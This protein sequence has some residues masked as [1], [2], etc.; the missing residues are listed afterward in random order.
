V[1]SGQIERSYLAK[2]SDNGEIVALYMIEEGSDTLRDRVLHASGWEPTS[3][4][5][6]WRFGERSD[7]DE[8]SRE[9]ARWFAE[10][11]GLGEFVK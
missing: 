6:D 7:I 9:E 4:I 8:I 11:L 5:A 3:A 2:V 1:G 10:R